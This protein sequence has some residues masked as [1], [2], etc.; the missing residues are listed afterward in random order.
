MN[1]TWHLHVWLAVETMLLSG[2]LLPTKGPSCSEGLVRQGPE[3]HQLSPIVGMRNQLLMS[4][5]NKKYANK[6]LSFLS[7]GGCYAVLSEI[8]RL[9]F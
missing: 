2:W 3:G 1:T 9:Y 8:L 4:F 7:G 6:H 5:K